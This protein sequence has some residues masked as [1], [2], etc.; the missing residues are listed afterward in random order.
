[1]ILAASVCHLPPAPRRS[2]PSSP[3]PPGC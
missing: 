1:M 2:A 3:G